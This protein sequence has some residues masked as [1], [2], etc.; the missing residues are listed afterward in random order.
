MDT[1]CQRAVTKLLK[2]NYKTGMVAHDCS[3]SPGESK[4]GRPRP[5]GLHKWD[6]VTNKQAD[7]TILRAEF[8]LHISLLMLYLLDNITKIGKDLHK[9]FQS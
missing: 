7:Q 1:N 4:E 6:P 3:P 2:Q 8:L 9:Q 5:V